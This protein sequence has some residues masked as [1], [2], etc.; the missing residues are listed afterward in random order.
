M[1]TSFFAW[2]TMRFG[3]RIS[4]RRGEKGSP[5]RRFNFAIIDL[6]KADTYPMNY[7]CKLPT[8]LRLAGG[9]G[10]AFV[11]KFGSTSYELARVLLQRA[12]EQEEP[13]EIRTEIERRLKWLDPKPAVKKRC[14]RC[15]EIFQIKPKYYYCKYKYCPE[16]LKKRLSPNKTTSVMHKGI[17]F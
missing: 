7:I 5:N 2:T 17:P 10:N 15:K 11:K 13:P 16:C 14:I 3:L 8:T 6:D 12:L 9:N 4:E 1:I